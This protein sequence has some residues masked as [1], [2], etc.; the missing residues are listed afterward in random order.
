MKKP[1][2]KTVSLQIRQEVYA[3]IAAAARNRGFAVGRGIEFALTY[4]A[5]HPECFD[6][7]VKEFLTKEPA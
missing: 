3:A 5:A 4:V 2:A 6:F 1:R 7:F